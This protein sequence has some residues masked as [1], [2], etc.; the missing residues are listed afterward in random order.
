MR[1]GETT[2]YA[3]G[4]LIWIVLGAALAGVGLT[5]VVATPALVVASM[6]L[7]PWAIL[8]GFVLAMPLSLLLARKLAAKH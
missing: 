8:A 7:L 3:L 4:L 1:F 5:I 2:M 6:K